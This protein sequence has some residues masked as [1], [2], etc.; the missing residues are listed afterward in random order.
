MV[1]S[2]TVAD[3]LSRFENVQACT[4]HGKVVPD[5]WTARCPSCGGRRSLGIMRLLFGK[6]KLTCHCGC[7]VEEIAEGA[8]FGMEVLDG[9]YAELEEQAALRRG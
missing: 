6:V 8:G 4:H 1:K 3:V 5:R 7:S 2:N 9:R